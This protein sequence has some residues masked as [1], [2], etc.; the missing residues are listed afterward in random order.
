MIMEDEEL[1]LQFVHERKLSQESYKLY[2]RVIE[3]Y[4]E[5]HETSFYELLEEADNEEEERINPSADTPETT[6]QF[7]E[8]LED[9]DLED[10][11]E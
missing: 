1:L 2:K 11:Q 3:S 10:T 6:P 8:E 9:E 4:T 5:F 7:Q